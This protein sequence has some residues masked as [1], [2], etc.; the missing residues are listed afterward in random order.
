MYVL[1]CGCGTGI[2]VRKKHID[3]LPTIKPVNKKDVIKFTPEDSI[4]GWSDAIGAIMSSYFTEDQP[5]P[6]LFGKNVIIDDSKIRAKG[7]SISHQAGKAPGPEPLRKAIENIRRLLDSIA[8]ERKLKP[9]EAADICLFIAD[10][11]L[12]GGVRRAS[13]I[14]LFD[15][16]D[17][18]M[19]MAKTG[20]WDEVNPQ[21]RL[22]NNTIFQDPNNVT[23]EEF[24]KLG[25][26][27]KE[28][29]E[30]AF[31]FSKN[32]DVVF[33]PCMETSLLPML[34]EDNK[35]IY[36]FS[37][38]NL[39]EIN[40]R[41]VKTL[42]DFVKAAE[43][44][45]ALG[46]LQAGYT[47]FG[48]LTEA[49]EKIAKKQA[50]IGVSITG[51]MDSPEMLFNPE[52]QQEAALAVVRMNNK[53]S[54]IIGI[55]AAYNTCLVK[56]SGTASLL[57]G[58][59]SGIH[60]QHA[61]RYFRNV[62]C[63]KMEE[64]LQ[65]FEKHN[66]A[67][68]S[69]SVYEKSDKNITFLCTTPK[70][71]ITKKTLTAIQMLERIHLTK[72]NWI[73]YG[74]N[75]EAEIIE[76]TSHNISNTVTVKDDEWEMVLEFIYNNRFDLTGVSLLSESGDKVY[77]Q[78]PFITVPTDLEV[79]QKYGVGAMFAS[80]V[81]VHALEVFND[82]L[83]DACNFALDNAETENINLVETNIQELTELAKKH[84]W[85]K[86]LKKFANTYFN[87]DIRQTTY[88]LKD[89]NNI[90]RWEDLSKTIKPV[91]WEEFFEEENNTKVAETV[92]CAGGA[93]ELVRI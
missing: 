27:I 83:W 60:A 24:M 52:Y 18:E 25:K 31:A 57:L 32:D 47:D 49:S 30:P 85:A 12:A 58:T 14:I 43:L 41:L 29:G 34:I 76:N 40:G 2:S 8:E 48:Y 59:G 15:I 79:L 4:E 70:N 23:K 62:T 66:P 90:K 26:I 10:A 42:D 65:F 16:F 46:T 45:S 9:I 73:D 50:Q 6:E 81:I 22:G 67:L 19:L 39:T 86:R 44:A 72:K 77:N 13:I 5:F 69:D 64:P 55:N 7:S 56:P 28:F 87:G 36:G 82:S 93:C 92:A 35:P 78:A 75:P 33:N 17:T 38:C 37:F 21:R 63:N 61:P 89:V 53:I 3:M 54:K 80:G 68:V 20:N 88:C 51:F 1:L 91:P 71:A 11:V 84:L 74:K